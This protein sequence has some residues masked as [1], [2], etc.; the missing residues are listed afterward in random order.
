MMGPGLA[1]R[2]QAGERTSRAGLYGLYVKGKIS[3]RQHAAHQGE[4]GD[5]VVERWSWC[6][7]RT[8]GVRSTVTGYLATPL[9]QLDWLITVGK[10][11][12]RRGKGHRGS[13]AVTPDARSVTCGANE[14]SQS[15]GL[16]SPSRRQL[17]IVSG[18]SQPQPLQNRRPS[19]PA[20]VNN[21]IPAAGSG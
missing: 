3:A 7:L 12:I 15:A 17:L 9:E 14:E 8:T 6:E 2:R 13:R 21:R 16:A 1:I 10:V 4:A 5:W 20:R 19:T 11:A 18:P